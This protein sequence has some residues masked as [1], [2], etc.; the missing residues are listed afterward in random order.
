MAQSL[1][2]ISSLQLIQMAES[3][4]GMIQIAL[5]KDLGKLTSVATDPQIVQNILADDYISPQQ[6]LSRLYQLLSIL[7]E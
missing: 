5:E 1:E 7:K 4:S 6:T 2:A 3:L